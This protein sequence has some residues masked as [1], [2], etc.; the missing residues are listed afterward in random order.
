MNL[1]KEFLLNERALNLEKLNAF[2]VKTLKGNVKR[3]FNV[4]GLPPHEWGRWGVTPH[5]PAMERGGTPPPPI[6]GHPF[7]PSST[8]LLVKDISPLLELFPH[9]LGLA[10][11]MFPVA[12]RL[13]GVAAFADSLERGGGGYPVAWTCVR[14]RM[15]CWFAALG[16]PHDLEIGKRTTTSTMSSY[17]L[18]KLVVFEDKFSLDVCSHRRNFFVFYAVDPTVVSEPDLC[19][20][21]LHG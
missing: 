16:L 11:Y 2:K 18:T 4:E 3:H 6:K 21:A 10:R 7:P 15:R 14:G 5:A 17:S 8:H 20:G 1:I 9:G 12:L 19:V 13:E